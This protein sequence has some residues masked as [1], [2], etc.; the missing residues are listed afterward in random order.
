MSDKTISTELTLEEIKY[1]MLKIST[2]LNEIKNNEY[3]DD[4]DKKNY[5]IGDKLL[6]KFMILGGELCKEK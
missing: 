4:C 6:D 1:L 3:K 2:N 5:E